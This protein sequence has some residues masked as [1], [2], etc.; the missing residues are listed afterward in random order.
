MRTTQDFTIYAGEDMTIRVAVTDESGA[1]KNLSGA[2]AA[3]RVGDIRANEL[4]FSKDA[5][6][7]GDG[8]DGLIEVT[9]TGIESALWD[10]RTFDYQFVVID[11]SAN[12]QVVRSGLMDVRYML[13]SS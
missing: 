3:F 6:V 9:L 13:P 7:V 4:A 5:A 8:S 2:T 1:V 11:A 10:I 12:R